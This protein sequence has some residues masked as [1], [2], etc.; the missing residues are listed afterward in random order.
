MKNQKVAAAATESEICSTLEGYE[1]EL[2]PAV[3]SMFETIKNNNNDVNHRPTKQEKSK[4]IEDLVQQNQRLTSEL[5][6]VSTN[7]L[8]YAGRPA[9][10]AA[11]QSSGLIWNFK[12]PAA[13]SWPGAASFLIKNLARFC[14]QT[15]IA[16]G[17]ELLH[18]LRAALAGQ[19]GGTGP[20]P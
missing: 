5:A 17:G 1:F 11:V 18:C 9:A 4:L 15:D 7:C 20:V 13:E 6:E 2:T 16:L 10:A 14:L 12:N 19:D 3:V 8:L